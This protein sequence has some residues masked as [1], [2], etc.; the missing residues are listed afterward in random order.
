MIKLWCLCDAA[1][2]YCANLPVYTG[3]TDRKREVG[4][5]KRVALDLVYPTL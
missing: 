3:M 5:S 2:A 4:Q 1:S